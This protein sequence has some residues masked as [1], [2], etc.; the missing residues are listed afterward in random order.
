VSSKCFEQPSVRLQAGL[1]MQL[2][3]IL[4][5]IYKQSGQWQGLF[6]YQ[7]RP[8]IDMILLIHVHNK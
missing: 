2:Y 3:G 5:C 6:E 8:V 4:S 7:I 1:Y